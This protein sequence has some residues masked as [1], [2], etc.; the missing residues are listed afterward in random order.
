MGNLKTGTYMGKKKKKVDKKRHKT[1]YNKKPA[2]E[3]ISVLFY[4][5]TINIILMSY[6]WIERGDREKP[7]A[8]FLSL[9]GTFYLHKL[10]PFNL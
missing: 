3:E 2:A 1:Q 7:K 6:R 8:A 9:N 10:T 5:V 4:F